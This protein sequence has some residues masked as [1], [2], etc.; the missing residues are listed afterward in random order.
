MSIIVYDDWRLKQW[1]DIFY[2]YYNFKIENPKFRFV[3][4]QH[5]G[6]YKD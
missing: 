4:L 1:L 6:Y 2:N 3:K 5:M